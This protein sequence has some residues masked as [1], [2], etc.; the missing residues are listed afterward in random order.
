MKKVSSMDIFAL[1]RGK[2]VK[3]GPNLCSV[4]YEWPLFALRGGVKTVLALSLAEIGSQ[5]YLFLQ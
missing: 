5:T 2:G 3:F 1:W 4:I